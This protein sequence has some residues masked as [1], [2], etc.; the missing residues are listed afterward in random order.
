MTSAEKIFGGS[1]KQS[2]HE[3]QH[4]MSVSDL[5]AGLMIVFLFISIALMRFALIERDKIK[6]VAIAYQDN[7]V[8]IFEALDA[9]FSDD[10]EEWDAEIQRDTLEFKFKSPE[11]L[12]DTGAV[13]LKPKFQEILSDFFPRYLAVLDQF[14]SSISEIKIEGHTS[15]IWNRDSSEDDAYFNNMYLSQGR[16]REV[17]RY[18]YTIEDVTPY[19]DWVRGHM[20]AVGYSSSRPVLDENGLENNDRSRRVAFRIVTNAELQIRKILELGT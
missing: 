11:V 10:L 16:T 8:A 7:Q 15:S 18:I 2:D 4:W 19:R 12:F 9:E 1:K 6:E 14:K 17:L 20:A 5:M 3:S 13:Q